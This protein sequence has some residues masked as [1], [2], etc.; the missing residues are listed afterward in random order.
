M[1][2][3]CSS[4]TLSRSWKTSWKAVPRCRFSAMAARALA[5]ESSANASRACSS[6]WR[7]CNDIISMSLRIAGGR[8]P[9][10][11]RGLPT[12]RDGVVADPLQRDVDAQ[13]RG[14]ETQVA[15]A[16]QV[17]GDEHVARR[18]ISRDR[19]V[20]GMVA[21]HH[22]G[23]LVP[24]GLEERLGRAPQARDDGFALRRHEVPELAEIGLKTLFV[25]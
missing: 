12:D 17:A 9:L 15:G 2:L 14:D 5:A 19:A 21:Q 18:S 23:R 6:I 25:V 13:H 4:P 1:G 11:L 16:R 10:E 24:V 7:P 8:L 20:D 3:A 22:D